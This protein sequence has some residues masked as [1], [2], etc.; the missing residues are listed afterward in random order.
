MMQASPSC[1]MRGAAPRDEPGGAAVPAPERPPRIEGDFLH[2]G[3]GGVERFLLWMELRIAAA[4]LVV[5]LFA[6]AV[7]VVARVVDLPIP[8]LGELAIVAMSPLTFLGAAACTALGSHI[9]I[10]VSQ[11]IPSRSA[12]VALAFIA[13]LGQFL[14]GIVFA[15]AAW[16][17]V[18]YAWFSGERLI[19][20]GIPLYVPG[21]FVVVGSVLV[22]V[23]ALLAMRRIIQPT[24]KAGT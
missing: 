3:V 12:R 20:L 18:D 4:S 14:F 24:Q 2:G 19:D 13:L 11:L 1:E 9:S 10:E 21:G 6:V 15:Y 7:S 8:N 22:S 17:F 16:D 23:H 5:I